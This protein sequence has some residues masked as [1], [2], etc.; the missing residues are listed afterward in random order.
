LAGATPQFT[1]TNCECYPD[2][3]A[4]NDEK[5]EV[6]YIGRHPIGKSMTDST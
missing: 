1:D 2:A 4:V 3:G 5:Y 6:R